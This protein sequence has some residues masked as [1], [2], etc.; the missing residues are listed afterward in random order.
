MDREKLFAIF[1]EL[2]FKT[3]LDRVAKR[4]DKGI[5]TVRPEIKPAAQQGAPSLFDDADFGGE[6]SAAATEK[7]EETPSYIRKADMSA[8]DYRMVTDTAALDEMKRGLERAERCGLFVMADGENDAMS[9]WIGTAVATSE[10][11]AFFVPADFGEGTAV[12]LDLMARGDIEKVSFNAKRDYV[13]AG[14]ASH[15]FGCGVGEFL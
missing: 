4:L 11:K 5:G 12:A 15:G 8:V 6:D 10:G 2:E 3:L 9:A 7:E 1:R 13:V 14:Q